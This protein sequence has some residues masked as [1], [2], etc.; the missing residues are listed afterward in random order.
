MDALSGLLDKAGRDSVL[1][2]GNLGRLNKILTLSQVSGGFGG[3][4]K[5]K[6]CILIEELN[7]FPRRIQM[8]S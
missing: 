8:S 6:N 2:G 5:S 7:E 1:L 3:L 4:G